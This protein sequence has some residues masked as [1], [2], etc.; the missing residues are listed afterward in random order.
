MKKLIFEI[1]IIF[2]FS[3]SN[4]YCKE[5]IKMINEK[6]E[7]A[8]FNDLLEC[9]KIANRVD[10]GLSPEIAF[11]TGDFIS[12]LWAAFGKPQE[13]MYEGF[14]YTIRHKETGIVFTAY[15]AGSGPAYGG[16]S[17]QEKINYVVEEFD[18]L[19][20]KV[21]PADCEIEYET[22]FGTMLSGSKNGV[23]YDK[24]K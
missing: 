20:R 21:E 24:K 15:S 1:F 23:P 5:G 9:S 10:L 18:N 8:N 12:R 16:S 2:L 6:Y 22:D 19:L 3:C 17:E 13:L 11:S 4:L 14:N 7:L